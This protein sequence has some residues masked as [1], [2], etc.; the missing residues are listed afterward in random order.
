MVTG[1]TSRSS[2]WQW[3]WV[4]LIDE[5]RPPWSPGT[6]AAARSRIDELV[7]RVAEVEADVARACGRAESAAKRV[8]DVVR[9]MERW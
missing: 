5:A 3:F 1:S 7:A 9:G 4:C 2:S 6:V 8:E